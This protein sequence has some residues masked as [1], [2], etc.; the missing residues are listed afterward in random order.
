MSHRW[1]SLREVRGLPEPKGGAAKAARWFTMG[2]ASLLTVTGC[3]C[4][5]NEV[6]PAP[7]ATS[8]ALPTAVGT[9]AVESAPP[10]VIPLPPATLVG[11]SIARSPDGKSLYVADELNS[12][13]HRVALPLSETSAFESIELPGPPAQV[14]VTDSRVLVTIRNPGLLWVGERATN[15]A[16]PSLATSTGAGGS[17]AAPAPFVRP[18]FSVALPPDAF[19]LT[20]TEEGRAVVSSAWPAVVSLVDPAA[21]RVV[22]SVSVAREPRGIVVTSEPPAAYVTHLVGSAITRLAISGEQAPEPEKIALPAAPLRAQNEPLA[23][24]LGYGATLSPDGKRY[25]V[26]RHALGARGKNA[27]FGAATVDVLDVPSRTPLAP[28]LPRSPRFAKS[29]LAEQLI[30]GGDTQFPGSSLTPFT[31]PRAVIYRPSTQTLL[32]AGEGDDRVTELDALALDPSMAVVALY[33]V[34]SDY[35]PTYHVP[36]YCA[37]PSGLALSQ[38]EQRLWVYCGAT[39]DVV[40]VALITNPAAGGDDVASS[41]DTAHRADEVLPRGVVA[42]RH[43]LDD[44]LGPGGATGRKLF[45]SATDF[46]SSGG[47]GCAGCHPEGRDDGHVWHEATF[48]TEDGTKTNFVGHAANIPPEAHTQGYARR[49]PM[50]AGRVHAPGPYGWHGESPTVT[51]RVLVGFDLHRWGAAPETPPAHVAKRASALFDFVRRGLVL[52]PRETRPLTPEEQ[53]GKQLFESQ[54]VGCAVCHPPKAGFT[55]RRPYRLTPPLPLAHGFDEDP[56]ARYKIPDLRYLA[57]RAPYFHDGSAATLEQLL[58]DNN[59]RMGSTA[60]LSVD[61]RRALQAYL[62]TL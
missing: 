48:T 3:K 43:L 1:G 7:S 51:A 16:M 46:P 18:L 8:E 57:Q 23:A 11:A 34:G 15:G 33:E 50:L 40:E 9:T 35:H 14:V 2:V 44:P 55:T 20:L 17:S 59:Y 26:A 30:S 61:E 31:Q 45:Y 32:V 58:A 10:V 12:K 39:N 37:A 4:S 42:L 38:D 13:L 41:A 62:E 47:L 5:K 60:Q 28:E 19:G 25:F 52:P 36:K 53:L 6:T 49:T 21:Q 22:W 27:W 56:D 24:S 29:E 54:G